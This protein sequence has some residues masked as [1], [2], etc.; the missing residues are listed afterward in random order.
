[1]SSPGEDVTSLAERFVARCR[2]AGDTRPW[3]PALYESEREL[4]D[5]GDGW[6]W[7][8][9]VEL[10][11]LCR[12]RLGVM[13]MG[14]VMCPLGPGG[15]DDAHLAGEP[16]EVAGFLLGSGSLDD[17]VASGMLFVRS[18]AVP[19]EGLERLRAVVA[20]ALRRFVEGSPVA[21]LVFRHWPGR[22]RARG[23]TSAASLGQLAEGAGLA[24]AAAAVAA[25][26]AVAPAAGRVEPRSLPTPA[27]LSLR[28]ASASGL[29]A[30]P[31]LDAEHLR[32]V[33]GSPAATSASE[34]AGGSA[35]ARSDA[36]DGPVVDTK[37]SAAVPDEAGDTEIVLGLR[38]RCDTTVGGVACAAAGT[39]GAA[40]TGR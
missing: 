7:T 22:V 25:V 36:P 4:G 24:V 38:A 28:Y 2:E 3:L 5:A 9:G 40:A 33:P 8:F 6:G 16:V 20:S 17:A 29:A 34:A 32:G 30:P 14:Q 13:P 27:V 10:R 15:V 31:P 23:Y 21:A 18:E 35:D 37:L 1:V 11:G 26:L 39:T 12:V 19:R